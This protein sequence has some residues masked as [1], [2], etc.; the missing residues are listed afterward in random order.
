MTIYWCLIVYVIFIG[1]SIPHFSFKDK[2]RAVVILTVFGIVIV[3]GLRA[4]TVGTD[5]KS[6]IPAFHISANWD[7]I[8]GYKFQNYEFGFS[9]LTQWLAKAGAN[10]TQ[11]L[12]AI[13]LLIHSLIGIIIYKYSE[14]PTLSFLIYICMGIFTFTFSGLRQAI[15]I[16]IIFFSY[17]FIKNKKLIPFLVCIVLAMSM[18]ATAIVFV[19]A[20]WLY[21]VR[22]PR[23]SFI[24][25]VPLTVAIF[26][27]RRQLYILIYSIYK[28]GSPLVSDTGAYTMLAIMIIIYLVSFLL[29]VETDI[30]D[31]EMNGYRNMMLAAVI[32]QIFTSQ[33]DVIGRAG[34]YYFM[35]ANLLLPRLVLKQRGRQK[36]LV[37]TVLVL[38]IFFFYWWTSLRTGSLS[39]VPYRFYW[40]Y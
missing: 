28:G 12:L 10:D 31:E 19:P 13:T 1:V 32:I 2:K 20:Y 22:I 26:V 6:Y 38:F 21:K 7:L 3:Q 29:D 27:L 25:I 30:Y 36:L 33:S 18:H 14:N 24:L 37:V 5:L 17:V 8:G 40:Q 23:K 16:S 11:Y 9:L 15:A 39:T 34:Y 35:F 4:I